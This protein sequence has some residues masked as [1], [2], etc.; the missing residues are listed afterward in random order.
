MKFKHQLVSSTVLIATALLSASPAMAQSASTTASA[1][2]A[3]P[4]HSGELQE[5]VVTAEK[6]A[7]D[8]NKVPMSVT[9]FTADQL[10]DAG[11]TQVRDLA[12]I[13]AGLTYADSGAGTPIYTLRGVGFSDISLAGRPTVSVYVDQ[14]PLPF[15]IMT[16]GVGLD[17]ERVEVLKGPQGTLFGTNTTGGAINFIAAKPTPDV[18]TGADL[19][20]GRF[21]SNQLT[22]FVSGPVT[23]TLSARMVVEHD[24]M[25]AWQQNYTNGDKLGVQDF[26]NGRLT[27]DWRPT[28]QLNAT[29]TLNGWLDRSDTQAQQLIGV[30]PTTPFPVPELETYPLAPQNNRAAGWDPGRNYRKDNN[31]IQANLRLDYKVADSLTLTSLTSYSHYRENQLDDLDGTTIS[32]NYFQTLGTLRS[33]SEELRLAG[34]LGDH[35]HFTLGANYVDDT[36]SEFNP[37][38]SPISSV[39]N[40]FTALLDTPLPVTFD[41]TTNQD[42][43]TKAAFASF[44]YDLTRAFNIYAGGRY[45]DFRTNFLGCSAD[46]GDGVAATIFSVVDRTPVQRGECFTLTAAGVPGNVTSTLQEHNFSWRAGAQWTAAPRVMFYANVSRGYKA[47]SFPIIPAN[48]YQQFAPVAQESVLAYEA[49]F[50]VGLFDRALQLNGAVFRYDYTD[51]QLLGSANLPGVGTILRLVNIP[52][53]RV[54]GA[55]IELAATPARGLRISTAATYIKSKVTSLFMNPDPLGKV[56]NFEGEPFPNTPEWQG[57]ADVQYEWPVAARLKAFLGG[58]GSYQ[59]ATNSQFGELPLFRTKAYGLLDLRAGLETEDGRWRWTIWGRNVTDTYYWTAAT[60]VQDTIVR[61][62]GM[63]A[64]YGISLSYRYR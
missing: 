11:V 52:E 46:S 36:T 47:G 55:E 15:S 12:K 33:I 59:S 28:D 4:P 60:H 43:I 29:F 6:R 23:S 19:S 57:S 22:A 1:Q 63:P 32:N 30:A 51:K 58:T 2:N 7:E 16:R 45:T 31:F 3:T 27:L 34:S 53:S 21:N 17:L 20:Y 38:Y 13:T 24:G 25:D 62:T 42:S 18:E 39:S 50:K 37:T 40:L 5:V 44:D 54:D 26:W 41:T 35:G 9:A 10:R 56:I 8:I 49:G 64:T 61:Y 48:D 14:A